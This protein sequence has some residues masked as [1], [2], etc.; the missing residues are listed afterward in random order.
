MSYNVYKIDRK[1]RHLIAKGV[2]YRTAEIY[3]ETCANCEF[4]DSEQAGIIKELP[5][6]GSLEDDKICIEAGI[7]PRAWESAIIF[8][9][10]ACLMPVLIL[11]AYLTQ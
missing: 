1:G 6:V 7:D 4:E 8:S 9:V 11:I 5:E 10:C 3:R 2:D